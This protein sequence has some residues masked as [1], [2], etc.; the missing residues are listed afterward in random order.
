MCS[1]WSGS[2]P[3]HMY[4]LIKAFTCV[5]E[6]FW[7]LY[8]ALFF[9]YRNTIPCNILHICRVHQ[10]LNLAPPKWTDIILLSFSQKYAPSPSCT[11]R[12]PEWTFL[13]FHSQPPSPAVHRPSSP[14]PRPHSHGCP[15]VPAIL[16]LLRAHGTLL[17]CVSALPLPLCY[18]LSEWP[19]SYRC[20][21]ASLLLKVLQRGPV[22]FWSDPRMGAYEIQNPWGTGP[23]CPCLLFP[24]SCLWI[25]PMC[26]GSDS[27]T[28][29]HLLLLI[30]GNP[31]SSSPLVL[32]PQDS[33][34]GSLPGCPHCSQRSPRGS[35]T[36]CAW[37]CYSWAYLPMLSRLVF[38][39]V[40][41]HGSS[42]GLHLR[43]SSGLL[44]LLTRTRC[45]HTNE[46]HLGTLCSCGAS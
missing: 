31:S 11:A 12:K 19:S 13:T 37:G 7:L 1:D 8:W 17:V 30:L 9:S 3:I 25:L 18:Q 15:P 29:S 4:L 35:P 43:T 26:P 45:L 10:H 40:S 42:L 14:P 34:S 20:D 16:S 46:M 5:L 28:T 23:A 21:H 39:C 22:S 41:P 2:I 33:S 32:I 6:G 38:V 24:S 44:H 27:C 36:R